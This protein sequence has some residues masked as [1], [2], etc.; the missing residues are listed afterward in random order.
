MGPFDKVN[1]LIVN[2][3]NDK[4]REVKSSGRKLGI[5]HRKDSNSDSD[6]LENL[7]VKYPKRAGDVITAVV[8]KLRR[9][10]FYAY[11]GAGRGQGG[12]KGSTFYNSKG[13][14]KRT[15]TGSLGQAGNPPRKAKHFLDPVSNDAENLVIEVA[16]ATCDTIFNTAF[17]NGQQ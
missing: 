16:A 11:H 6:S 10:L 12:A 1:Q 8:Y 3:G 2:W 14:R 4:L 5:R 7:S 17:N 15:N 13:E 9:V